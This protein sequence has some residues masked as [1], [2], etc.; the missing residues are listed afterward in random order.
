MPIIIFYLTHFRSLGQK[1]KNNFVRV[2][3]VQMST[4]KFAFE[5][6]WPL[7]GSWMNQTI[8]KPNLSHFVSN[9]KQVKKNLNG[10]ITAKKFTHQMEH[11]DLDMYVTWGQKSN[12]QTTSCC[13][14]LH[15]SEVIFTIF[16][17]EKRIPN[18]EYYWFFCVQD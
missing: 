2:F 13:T 12:I 14:L 1:S 11:S 16:F 10:Q 5:I 3:L 6:Y 18:F 15:L 9:S 7:A 8:K 17:H 4:R